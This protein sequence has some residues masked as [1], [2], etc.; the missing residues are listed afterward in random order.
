MTATKLSMRVTESDFACALAAA[1]EGVGPPPHAAA[2]T[3]FEE[4]AGGW[5]IE[6]YYDARPDAR[7]LADRL[8]GAVGRA[9]PPLELA[10]VPNLNWVAIS[11]AALPPIRAG[12]FVVLG[13]HDIARVPHGPNAIVI[14]AGEA[15]GTA[16]HATTLGC[17]LAID[18]LTRS[19][20][21]RRVLDLGC[22]SGVLAIAA[23]RALPR[24]DVLASDADPQA[25]SIALANAAANGVGRR[26][27]VAC[28]DG[29]AH[30]WLR[31]A[32]PFDL[33]I[34]NILA[35][36]LQTMASELGR[37]LRVGGSLVLSGL[38]NHEAPAVTAAYVAQ[39][40]EVGEHRR[41]SGW[42]VLTL[43]R[44]A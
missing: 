1:L 44:R 32:I 33:V 17:L 11:Q 28:A 37:T 27:A 39:D 2:V 19:R 15:F 5:R 16:H 13:S 8:L 38:L 25:V 29:L 21:F 18:R 23:A 14:D 34:A 3:Q 9:L 31:Q 6:A 4:G 20:T 43:R 24:A 40:F 26:I 30:P 35:A 22:G 36:P 41:L 7:A 42:S 10:E 12:R